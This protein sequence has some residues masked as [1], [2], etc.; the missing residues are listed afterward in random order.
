MHRVAHRVKYVFN[1]S[2][3]RDTNHRRKGGGEH[4][5][6]LLNS[7]RGGGERRVVEWVVKE[8]RHAPVVY[9]PCDDVR[10]ELL[11]RTR[12]ETFCPFKGYASYWTIRIENKL[13]ENAVWAYEDPFEEVAGLR[14]YMSFYVGRGELTQ[15][16]E[17]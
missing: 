10:M 17:P 16:S 3:E 1:V 8:S 11:E 5:K 7:E 9:F 12:H 2:G 4:R 15:R 6:C 14:G 13:E